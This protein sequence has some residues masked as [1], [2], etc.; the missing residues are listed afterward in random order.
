MKMVG[1]AFSRQ[2]GSRFLVNLDPL[3]EHAGRQQTIIA[4][5]GGGTR[6]VEV[7]CVTINVV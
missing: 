5:T 4:E 7:T 3:G 6:S 1:F 2:S